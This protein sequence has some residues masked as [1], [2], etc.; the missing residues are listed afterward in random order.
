MYRMDLGSHFILLRLLVK[1][2]AMIYI[3]GG[4]DFTPRVSY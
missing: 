3:H 2:Y 1:V 4:V